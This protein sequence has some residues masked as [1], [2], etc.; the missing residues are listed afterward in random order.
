MSAQINHAEMKNQLVGSIS[1]F[2][3]ENEVNRF[4][5][6]DGRFFDAPLVGFAS[7]D[8][9]LFSDYKTLVG[10][11]HLTPKE[12]F[13]L[14]HGKD[15][16]IGGTVISLAFPLS[17]ELRNTNRGKRDWPSHEAVLFRSY[18]AD[19]VP[20][21]T[22]KYVVDLLS[23][24]G[25]RAVAPG[26]ESWF[27]VQLT[28]EKYESNWS[29][30]HIAY[31]AGLGT[32]SLNDALI[33]E[34]GVAV[35][36]ASVVTELVLDTDTRRA[37]SHTE[38]CLMCGACIEKCPAGALSSAGHDKH[39]CFLYA[40]GDVSRELAVSHGGVASAGAGCGLCQIDVPCEFRVPAT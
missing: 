14:S 37:R 1:R 3:T 26:T 15:S 18:G 13:E 7:P 4:G 34:K 22:A 33:T 11:G 16:F 29:E 10:P 24:L 12:A 17:A 40:Y 25:F 30:R 23:G 21:G 28:A 39:K 2:V 31:A 38:N 36:L 8:D 20:M 35:R 6:I 32:F 5:E 9:S 19:Q 27:K